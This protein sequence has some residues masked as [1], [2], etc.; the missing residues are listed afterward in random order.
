MSRGELTVS[1]LIIAL[2]TTIAYIIIRTLPYIS[3]AKLRT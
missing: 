1:L 2:I 3:L